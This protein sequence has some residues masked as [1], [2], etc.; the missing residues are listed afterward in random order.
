MHDID[1]FA[2][3]ISQGNWIDLGENKWV[4]KDEPD[5]AILFCISD[6]YVNFIRS[7]ED[8]SNSEKHSSGD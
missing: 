5:S 8:D 6:L 1:K 4:P 3:W 7:L 2:V